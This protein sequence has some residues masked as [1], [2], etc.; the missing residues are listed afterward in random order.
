MKSSTSI[1]LI[2]IVWFFLGFSYYPKWEKPWSEAAISWDVSGYYHYLPAIFI[3]HDIRQQAWMN[4]INQ[5]YLPSPAQDQAFGHQNSGNK[6]NKYAIGQAV[7]FSPFFLVA[8]GYAK[9]TGSYPADGYSLPY[10][11]AIWFG[12][13]LF[14]ILGLILLRRILLRYFDDEVVKLTL[15]G[16]AIGTHWMEYAAITNGMN[17]TWLFTLLCVLILSTMRF[18]K[19]ADWTSVVGIGGSLGLAVLTRPTEIVWVLIPLLWGMTSVKA[20]LAYMLSHWKKIAVAVI[21]SGTIIFVQLAYWKY[22]AGEWIVYSYGDQGFNWL[23]PKIW[24]GLMGVNIGWW[25]YTPLML[26]AMLGWYGVYKKHNTIFWPAFLTTMLA[27]YITLS[28]AHFEGG[29]GLGQRNLIQIYPLM[30]FPLAALIGW[31]Y[32]TRV[33]RWSIIVI[34]AFNI[35][36]TGW[37]INQAHKGGFFQAGQ[38][39]TPYFYN[40]VLRSNPDPDLF[41][42]LDTKEYFQGAP[43]DLRPIYQ[44]DFE[45]DTLFCSTDWP[46]GGKATCLN[47]EVQSFGPVNL[48]VSAD[49]AQWIRLEADFLIQT[50][51]WDV[52]KYAQWIVQFHHGDQAIKTNLIRV[53]RLI[54]VDQVATHLYFDVKVPS[55]PY[56]RCTMSIWNGGST[57]S[58]LMDNLKVSCF[59]DR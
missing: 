31:F 16:L 12:S 44:I 55:G 58:L 47:A 51:E 48:P 54:P 7:L 14:S 8:H 24:R 15:F 59:K 25:I 4:D 29:G 34:I 46:A 28:W 13:L 40:V 42:L 23:H 6:V 21:I 11:F 10:Q 22:A 38:M 52:W 26:L 9:L 50:H 45:Q 30:A 1:I 43:Q 3:Y 18:Y 41:K 35:Y 32:Q 37:W 49:C 2:A 39:T 19:T 36:Y 53:Q 33:G 56:D 20:R 27:I 57:Q 5:K 17:H